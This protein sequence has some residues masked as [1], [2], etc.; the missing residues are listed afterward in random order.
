MLSNDEIRSAKHADLPTVLKNLGVNLVSEGKSFYLHEHD[1]LKFF[2]KNGIWIYKWWS[3]DEVDDGIQYLM[4]YCGMTFFEA[5]K[6]LSS[7]EFKCID[8]ESTSSIGFNIKSRKLIEIAVSKLFE[9]N[10]EEGYMYLCNDRGFSNETIIRYRLGWLPNWRQMPSKLVIPCYRSSGDLVRIKFRLDHPD[11]KG[12]RYKTMKGSDTSITF[13]SEIRSQKPIVIVES[14][15]DAIL[16][17]QEAGS[18]IGVLVLGGVG[19]RLNNRIVCYLNEKIP[20]KL[21]CL[22]NDNPGKTRSE[23]LKKV[24][25]NAYEWPIPKKYGKD[26]GEAW[27]HMSIKEW[28]LKGLKYYNEK[29]K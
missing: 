16:I 5:V 19:Y 7:K 11:L 22:D 28:I 23:S 15:L 13:T 21:I 18:E 26:P 20:V 17:A 8:E 25:K 2:K 4:K 10:G 29:R 3:R 1:S 14:E 27:I 9:P 12:K 6:L 24:L